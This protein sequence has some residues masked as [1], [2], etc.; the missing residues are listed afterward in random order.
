MTPEQ[1][2][3]HMHEVNMK[4]NDYYRAEVYRK[5]EMERLKRLKECVDMQIRVGGNTMDCL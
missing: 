5:R 2:K 1:H 3:Q 4:Y